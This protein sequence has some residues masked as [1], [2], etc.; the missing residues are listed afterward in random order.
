M[1][2]NFV[3]KF[4]VVF[5]RIWEASH[6]IKVHVNVFESTQDIFHDFLGKVREEFKPHRHPRY[7]ILPK[8][9]TIVHASTLSSSKSR[10]RIILHW[11]FN[12][13]KELVANSLLRMSPMIGK[14]HWF[15]STTFLSSMRSL[16]QRTV[17]SFLGT[18]KDE[19][20]HLLKLWGSST[21]NSTRLFSSLRNTSKC[22]RGTG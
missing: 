6:V 18:M 7:L 8:G 21:P 10:V 2:Q 16:I 20:A 22:M 15:L 14:G 12:F 11:N 4:D 19:L 1:V 17:V 5:P 3:Q 9:V 13:G